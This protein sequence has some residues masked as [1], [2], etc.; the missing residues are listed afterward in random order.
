MENLNCL[1]E[2]KFKSSVVVTISLQMMKHSPTLS[3]TNQDSGLPHLSQ[4]KLEEQKQIG[5]YCPNCGGV[6]ENRKCKLF[7]TKRGCGYMVTCSEW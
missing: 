2:R 6:L 5:L 4:Q 3:K 7:C 1:S